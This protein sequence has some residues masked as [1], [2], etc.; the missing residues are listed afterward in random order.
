[1]KPDD[2]KVVGCLLIT[3]TAR[4]IEFTLS[5][6]QTIRVADRAEIEAI[7]AGSDSDAPIDGAVAAFRL[8]RRRREESNRGAG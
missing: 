7:V 1:M 8:T 5:D 3:G 4:Y 2:L 6:G